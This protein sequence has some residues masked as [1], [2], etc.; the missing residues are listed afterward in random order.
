MRTAKPVSDDVSVR[1]FRGMRERVVANIDRRG[2]H[3]SLWD[4]AARCLA[5]QPQTLIGLNVVG[6]GRRPA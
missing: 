3:L 2:E 5:A 6:V 1:C 4:R